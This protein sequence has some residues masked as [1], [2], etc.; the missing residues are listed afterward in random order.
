VQALALLLLV[1]PAALT[2][3]VHQ[4]HSAIVRR[5]AERF[6]G[7]LRELGFRVEWRRHPWEMSAN[8]E[9]WVASGEHEGRSVVLDSMP[10]PMP[11]RSGL[12]Q[13]TRITVRAPTGAERAC[14]YERHASILRFAHLD[15]LEPVSLSPSLDAKFAAAAV[16]PSD[17]ERLDAEK[18]RWV[19]GRG[20]VLWIEIGGDDTTLCVDGSL[21]SVPRLLDGIDFVAALIERRPP[22]RP[23]VVPTSSW[24]SY[25]SIAYGAAVVSLPLTFWLCFLVPIAPFSRAGRNDLFAA[26]LALD[27]VWAVL[28]GIV[29]LLALVRPLPR[30]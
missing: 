25:W 26:A 11:N 16:V 21:E 12:L 17:L 9:A 2:Y 15:D 10:V 28:V 27:L 8:R 4:R 23:L 29:G 19:E 30:E 20:G 5:D 1:P 22:A 7:A 14:L 13:C 3:W 24:R 6:V 18:Q